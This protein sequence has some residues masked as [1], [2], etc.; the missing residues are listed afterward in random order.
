MPEVN[1]P[2]YPIEQ[3]IVIKKQKTEKRPDD[4]NIHTSWHWNNDTDNC[5][6]SFTQ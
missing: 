4:N 5:K 3:G 6:E 2:E 1:T